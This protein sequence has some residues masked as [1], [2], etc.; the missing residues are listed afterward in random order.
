MRSRNAC[1]LVTACLVVTPLAAC[2]EAP[3]R[4]DSGRR[5]G[6]WNDAAV[7]APGL[8]ADLRPAD[9]ALPDA[10]GLDAPFPD[11][12]DFD[13]GA[14]GAPYFE[15][16]AVAAG[17]G[18]P[19][20]PYRTAPD[21][22][23]DDV[24]TPAPGDHCDAE[25]GL[26]GAA[27]G[28]ADGDGHDDL[29][30]TRIGAPAALYANDGTGRF[31]DVSAARGL[32]I[33]EPTAG[34]AFG[35]VDD[36]GDLDLYV[37]VL[38][39]RAHRLYLN[40]GARFR[41]AAAERGAALTS[42]FP[43]LGS[44]VSFGDY[45]RDGD[46]DLYVGEWRF[47]TLV[48][49]GPSM[50]R[51]LRNRG[52]AMPGYFE[53][54]T[55]SAGVSMEDAWVGVAQRGVYVY[56]AAMLDLDD[57]GATDLA[58]NGDFRTSRL[59]WGGGPGG[60]FLEGTR[61]AGV[62]TETNAMGSTFADLDGDGDLDWLVTSIWMRFGPD[63]G[64]RLFRNDGRRR[65]TEITTEAGV[66]D[67]GWAWGAA[68]FDYD[69][70]RDDDLA[71]TNGWTFAPHVDDAMRLYRHDAPL[72]FV[73]VATEAGTVDRGQGRAIVVLDADEDGDLDLFVTR[74][75][76]RPLLF[77]NV[78]G[79]ERP[80]LR[81]RVRSRR[82]GGEGLGARV[83]IRETAGGPE[84]VAVIGASTHYVAQSERVA[85]FGLG[86]HAG[87]VAEVRAVLPNGTVLRATDVPSRSVV[88][89][90]EP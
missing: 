45:D 82:G 12:G 88:E 74:Y 35:D 81:V 30:V 55:A 37:T 56:A 62:G 11:V 26:A 50:S 73:D 89:L 58:I 84:R 38:G 80:W 19:H 42:T 83:T 79:N 32:A 2:R 44:T 14:P 20:G 15:E 8:D 29:F 13:A 4:P 33:T 47:R 64:N 90:V 21:C 22:L 87:P 66:L 59:F 67:A 75:G 24:T 34:A 36:D 77:R 51:L 40:E 16:V 60:T 28:D 41:E 61:A 7:D 6:G 5:D 63:W 9:A 25:W 18:A 65:F 78:R 53:D 23:F 27:V 43:L 69:H 68:F 57:D 70:D 86:D 71:A 46:L 1:A 39:G 72:R 85:H 54:V 48:H 52:P 76:D 10:P 49:D 3:P 31:T 17:L